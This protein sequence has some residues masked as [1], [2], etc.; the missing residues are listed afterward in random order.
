MYLCFIFI[1]ISFCTFLFHILFTYFSLFHSQSRGSIRESLFFLKWSS[2]ASRNIS[3]KFG[4]RNGAI[5]PACQAVQLKDAP[6]WQ[7]TLM[8][9]HGVS[10]KTGLSV[11]FVF[12]AVACACPNVSISIK[13]IVFL[14]FF[15]NKNLKI[16]NQWQYLINPAMKN[17]QQFQPLNM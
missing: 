11:L 3:V 13:L 8:F 16:D 9:C 17:A 14:F 6:W 5:F 12:A 4:G 15:S 1:C 7:Y 10:F 2:P